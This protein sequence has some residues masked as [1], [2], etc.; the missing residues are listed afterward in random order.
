MS[1]F[2]SDGTPII[3]KIQSIVS[4]VAPPFTLIQS[5][6]VQCVELLDRLDILIELCAPNATLTPTSKII[7]GIFA[8]QLIAEDTTTGNTYKGF[9]LE[10]ETRAY[11]PKVNQNR[12]VGKNNSGIVLI[13]T[14]YSFASDPNVLID[15]LKSI[16]DRDNLKAY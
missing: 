1:L 6:I 5:T 16:I 4:Q 2:K 11:T 12:A 9:I 14:K 13:F 10:I 8:T 15:E 3:P 7:D